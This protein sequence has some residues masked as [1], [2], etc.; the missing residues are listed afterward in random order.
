MWNHEMGVICS[1]GRWP[2]LR[3][4]RK[5]IYR[6]LHTHC[7]PANFFLFVC[8]CTATPAAAGLPGPPSFLAMWSPQR[9]PQH[10][11]QTVVLTCSYLSCPYMDNET[12]YLLEPLLIASFKENSKT[13]QM[14]CD[15]GYFTQVLIHLKNMSEKKEKKH[16]S[17]WIGVTVSV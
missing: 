12:I 10:K 13:P 9:S 3:S 15:P 17:G 1:F 7:T 4:N 6:L 2:H 16:V 8:C 5:D 14:N 11:I